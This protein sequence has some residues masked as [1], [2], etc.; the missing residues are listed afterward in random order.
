MSV[1]VETTRPTQGVGVDRSSPI[2]RLFTFWLPLILFVV[3]T[4]FPFYWMLVASLKPN[5]ELYNLRVFPFWVFSPTLDHYLYLFEKTLYARWLMN[6][7]I[8][9]VAST[10][11]SL[12]F[13]ILAGYALA[14]LRFVGAGVLGVAV[15]IS[16]LVP[17]TLLFIPM[18]D[19]IKSLNVADTYWALILTYPTFLIPFCTW[20]LMG[21]FKSIPKELEESAMIDGS[22]RLRAMVEI[23]LP[24]AMPG[25]LSAGIFA[26]TL[27]WNEFIYALVFITT[28]P[29]KT[30]PVG[31]VNELIRGD[32]FFWGSL[33]AGA[34]LGSV[35]VALIYSFFVEY[36]VAGL[37][38]GAVK[39]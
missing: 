24:L 3:L 34:L 39:G 28:T 37:T 5:N 23:V 8:V 1:A 2:K 16:Y 27:S 21:Y 9:A 4:L 36:Y 26:F 22:S 35:P 20:L 32:V 19:V 15:F 31:V 12:V 14:R 33:M 30:L 25:I 11:I 10:A 18:F 38:A 13:G 6:T 7:L 17:Q 29:M